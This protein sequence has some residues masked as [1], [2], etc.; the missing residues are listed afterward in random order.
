MKEFF[1]S[2]F[3]SSSD[4]IKNPF[5]GSYITAFLVYNWRAIFLLLFSNANIENKI[6]VIN[7]EYGNKGAVL[8]PL[9]IAIFYILIL[10]YINL[11]FDSLLTYSNSKKEIRKK[12]GIISKLEQKKAEAKYE[13]EI[14]DERAGTNEVEVLKNKID[15]LE[16]E[17]ELKSK[18][19]TDSIARNNE[20]KESWN[21]R[22]EQLYKE[23]EK[24][25]HNLKD[26][27]D[28]NTEITNVY[29]LLINPHQTAVRDIKNYLRSNL[30]NEEFLQL[31]THVENH[32]DQYDKLPFSSPNNALL[33]KAGVYEKDHY[34]RFKL[35]DEGMKFIKDLD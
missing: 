9:G 4:R 30:S 23:K 21:A 10:P 33:L 7:H 5:I 22:Y 14:A 24:I 34:K 12:A 13:R 17:N 35:T 32:Y 1:L 29:P 27:I 31:K 19:F 15:A 25:E 3:D 16:K 18:D 11:I 8:W 26:I 28:R 2:V 6:I 20:E